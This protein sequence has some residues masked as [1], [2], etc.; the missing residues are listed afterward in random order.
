[1]NEVNTLL[2][3]ITKIIIS[4][5]IATLKNC[6]KIYLIKN[7]EINKSGNFETMSNLK[8]ND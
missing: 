6:D 1:M 8:L 5:R 3:N 4:H 7:G 2:K